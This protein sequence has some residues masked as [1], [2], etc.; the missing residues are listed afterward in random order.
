MEIDVESRV[1]RAVDYF[2]AGYGCGQAVTAAFADLYGISE[3]V[4]LRIGA[5]F[6]GGVGKM[7]M[8]CGAVSALVI[9][10]GLQSEGTAAP[11]HSSKAE[12]Y[13]LVQ[14]VLG[15]FKQ[16][17]GSIVCAELLGI[18]PIEG[19]FTPAPRSGHYYASRPCAAKVASAA[20][21]WAEYLSRRNQ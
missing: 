12:C 1:R 7:R 8:M 2:M 21:I 18:K 9:L 6:G 11:D 13:R 15:A 4:A 19:D 17:N 16:Q 20:G 10:A 5:G 3:E 14:D